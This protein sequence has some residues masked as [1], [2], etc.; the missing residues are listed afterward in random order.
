MTY[1]VNVYFWRLSGGALRRCTSE[2]V[3]VQKLS[4]LQAYGRSVLGYIEV[5]LLSTQ[6]KNQSQAA[7]RAVAANCRQT[8]SF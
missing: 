3:A 7:L 1:N 4:T 6:E 2:I 5:D 8:S